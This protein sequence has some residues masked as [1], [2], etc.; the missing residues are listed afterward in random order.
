MSFMKVH[1]PKY[2]VHSLKKQLSSYALCTLRYALNQG[3]TLI[4]LLVVISIMAVLF[5]LTVFGLQGARA[6]S[7]DAKRKADLELIRSGLEIYKSDC[8]G[9]PIKATPGVLSSP[10]KGNSSTVSCQTTN[11]YIAEVPADPVSTLKDYRYFSDGV[12]YELCASLEQ[13]STAP[14]T[15]GS[16]S[17]CGSCQRSGDCVCNYKVVSP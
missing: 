4:E 15:C 12:T 9:Y 13:G 6:S 10:L 1:S 8:D 7:R 11:T 5:G 14:V 3:F 16:S 17:A 2:I